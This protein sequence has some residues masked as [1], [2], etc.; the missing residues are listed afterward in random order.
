MTFPA[1]E[2]LLGLPFV[3]ALIIA[4][5][6]SASR[7]SIGWMAAAAPVLGLGLLGMITPEVLDGVVV[8]SSHPWIEQLGL[9]FTLRIDGLAWMFAGLVLGI[10]A[11]VIMYARYYLS[12]SDSPQRF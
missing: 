6:R 1:L 5:S 7:S 2:I 12:D 8:Q 10:G 4:L 9:M 11:L 3:L